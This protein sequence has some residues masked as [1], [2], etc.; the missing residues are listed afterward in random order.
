MAVR[1][2]ERF[3]VSWCKFKTIHVRHVHVQKYQVIGVPGSHFESGG[4]AIGDVRRVERTFQ[5]HG[6]RV[7]RLNARHRPPGSG[8]GVRLNSSGF[9]FGRHRSASKSMPDSGRIVEESDTLLF[10]QSCP[11]SSSSTKI[12][13]CNGSKSECDGRSLNCRNLSD[14]SPIFFRCTASSVVNRAC[15]SFCMRRTHRRAPTLN[16]SVGQAAELVDPGAGAST[17]NPRLE[18]RKD[19]PPSQEFDR[20]APRICR[21]FRDPWV[22]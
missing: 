17:R 3:R 1:W 13:C 19:F 6:K 2:L 7:A 9:K 16:I 15:M 22:K 14:I 10:P 5:C 4:R 21:G 20:T 12:I 18:F 11:V 8:G